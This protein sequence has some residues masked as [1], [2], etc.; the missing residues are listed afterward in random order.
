MSQDTQHQTLGDKYKPGNEFYNASIYSMQDEEDPSDEYI[1]HEE[2][3]R[4]SKKFI[5]TAIILGILLFAGIKNPSQKESRML[6]REYL[7]E[8]LKDRVAQNESTEN[9]STSLGSLLVSTFAPAIIETMVR[10]ETTDY[11]LFTTFQSTLMFD[12]EQ[13]NLLSGIILFGKVIPFSS[14]LKC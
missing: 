11:I 1:P 12:E 14:D 13:S 4:Y 6:V 10:V 2:A 3:R 7:S 8:Q 9:E 5:I